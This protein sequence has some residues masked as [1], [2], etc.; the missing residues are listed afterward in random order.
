M[1]INDITEALVNHYWSIPYSFLKRYFHL[2]L[3][4]EHFEAKNW[5]EKERVKYIWQKNFRKVEK[6]YESFTFADDSLPNT[7]KVSIDLV[8]FVNGNAIENN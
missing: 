5:S 3:P 4:E 6:H 8:D 7:T 1:Q 2:E